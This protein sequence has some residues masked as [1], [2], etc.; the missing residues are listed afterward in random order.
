MT[1]N[2]TSKQTITNICQNAKTCQNLYHYIS[3]YITLYHILSLL[4]HCSTVACICSNIGWTPRG[5]NPIANWTPH[6]QT[7]VTWVKPNW[8]TSCYH[9][10]HHKRHH[11]QFPLCCQA[12]ALAT[13]PTACLCWQRVNNYMN[14]S[15]N[16]VQHCSTSLGQ[17]VDIH[18]KS[19]RVWVLK[20]TMKIL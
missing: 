8:M 15:V 7:W 20:Q 9:H 13:A 4:Y 2:W 1:Q 11:L 14:K 18:C 3:H 16:H 5:S 12:A 17:P 19:G 6:T 10:F